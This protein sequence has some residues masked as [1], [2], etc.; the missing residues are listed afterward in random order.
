MTTTVRRLEP[1]D[2]SVARAVARK[3]KDAD[4]S[5]A[6]AGMFLANTSNY[7]IVA[8]PAGE[9]AGF[10]LAYRL[11]RID[12]PTGQLFVYE[13]A[14]DPSHRHKGLGTQ[15]MQFARSIVEHERLMEAFT[16]TNRG[17]EAAIALYSGT[18][19][20][21]EDDRGMLFVYPGAAG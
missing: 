8:E 13:V 3:F 1:G 11:D 14:V 16:L 19:A 21:L 18:G 17:N 20:E 15:L 10:L 12:R 5:D 6:Q 2:E 9:L 4:I 7:L